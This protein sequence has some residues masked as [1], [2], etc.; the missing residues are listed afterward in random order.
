MSEGTDG[1]IGSGLRPSGYVSR[2]YELAYGAAS[3]LYDLVVWWGFL[4]LGGEAACRRAFARWVD[5]APKAAVVSLCCGTGST[6]RAMLE[7][8]PGLRITAV[9]LGRAQ[10]ARAR[11][12][13]PSGRIDYRIADAARTGLSGASFDRAVIGLALHEMPRPLRLRILR[14]AAR[15]CRPGGR[16]V[17]IEHGRPRGAIS[18]LLRAFWWFFWIPLNPEVATSRDLQRRGLDEEMRESGL[19]VLGRRATD[20]DWIEAFVAE[21]R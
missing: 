5:P 18:R 13:D 10:I 6:E 15:L 16:V 17:A 8:T 14:E 7:L 20:P 1:P 11:A 21:P 3:P 9:D 2:L 19:R 4:P 12:R